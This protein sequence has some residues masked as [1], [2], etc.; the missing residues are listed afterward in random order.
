MAIQNMYPENT[1][2]TILPEDEAFDS[3]IVEEKSMFLSRTRCKGALYFQKLIAELFG[4][5]EDEMFEELKKKVHEYKAGIA[6]ENLKKATLI[7]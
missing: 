6:K 3:M 7:S 4:Y 2:K 5:D 1:L